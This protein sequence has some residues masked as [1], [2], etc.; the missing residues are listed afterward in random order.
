[1]MQLDDK[2]DQ[3]KNHALK[4]LYP[5]TPVTVDRNQIGQLYRI[6]LEYCEGGDLNSWKIK[7][8]KT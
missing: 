3:A 7:Q 6:T 5:L 4:V 1:M 8:K 2:S